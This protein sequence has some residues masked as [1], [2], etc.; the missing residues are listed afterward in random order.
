MDKN[1]R[2]KFFFIS[3]L[4]I[5]ASTII[6]IALSSTIL[7]VNY[8]IKASKNNSSQD[9]NTESENTCPDSQ[10]ETRIQYLVE[11]YKNKR[12]VVLTFDDGPGKYS[13]YLVDELNKRNVNVTF[14]VLGEN[15][16]K[17]ASILQY[18]YEAGNDIGI[19]SYTHKI[20]TCLTNEEITEQI[21]KT[22][23]LLC[24]YIN[25]SPTLIRVPYG[26]ANDRVLSVTQSCNLTNILWDLDSRDWKIKNTDKI[27]NYML[28]KFKG[29]DIILMHDIYKTS[30][31]AAIKLVD[32]LQEKC[33]SFITI[34]EY[35]EI[36][37]RLENENL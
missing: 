34:S 8:I 7:Y 13:K 21:D 18:E 26:S 3:R 35:L 10:Y 33:Y 25:L 22:K 5:L 6:I 12:T 37:E 24:N 30:V 31:E 16:E 14:F 36:K 32:N 29:N 9:Y 17:K 23:E 20:F 4:N 11:Q 15:I 2:I 19:H 28:K 27:Y 1:S